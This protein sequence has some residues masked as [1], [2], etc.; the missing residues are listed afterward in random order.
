MELRQKYNKDC[1]KHEFIAMILP[2]LREGII[3]TVVGLDA[4]AKNPN[5]VSYY[6]SRTPGEIIC[7]EKN[8]K[9]RYGT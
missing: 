5:I 2:C 8:V 1:I 4:I 9:Q 7:S 3:Q 6:C